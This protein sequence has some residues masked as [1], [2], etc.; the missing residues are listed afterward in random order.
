MRIFELHFNPSPK[1]DLIFDSFCYEPENVYE[2][3]L[4]SLF[5]VGELKNTLPQHLKFFDNLANFLKKQYY[6]A[7]A[8]FS[9]ETALKEGLK[10]TNEFLEKIVKSGD[11]SWLGN[12]NSAVFNLTLCRNKWWEI[13]FTK[14]GDIK[15]LLLRDG[16]I[17]D[18]GKNLEFQDIEPYPLKIFGNIVSGKLVE[19][20]MVLVIT[21]DI[22]SVFNESRSVSVASRQ[23]LKKGKGFNRSPSVIE[24]IALISPFDGTEAK[25]LKDILKLKEQELLKTSG[26]CLLCFLT[27]ETWA[28]DKKPK[29]FTFQ[30]ETEKFSILQVFQPVVKEINL[31]F[32]HRASTHRREGEDEDG[33]LIARRCARVIDAFKGLKL[34]ALKGLE[35]LKQT[36]KKLLK[37]GK[38]RT[39]SRIKKPKIKISLRHLRI[40]LPDNLKKNLVSVFLLVIFLLLGFFIFK[41]EEQAKL[42]EY[43]LILAAVNQDILQADNFLFLKN[44]E[45]AFT[46]LKDSWQ[47]LLPLTEKKSAIQKEAVSLKN[48]LEG[49]LE[50][51]SNLEKIAEPE[52]FFE[53][54]QGDEPKGSSSPFANARVKE[55]I[56]QKMAY[57]E[58]SHYFFSSFSDNVY[59]LTSKAEK[60][61]LPTDQRF[62]EATPLNNY[63]LFL[64]KPNLVFLL[65]NDQFQDTLAL[66]LPYPDFTPKD[67]AAYQ[68]SLYF[69]DGKNGEIIKYPGPIS[70]GKDNPQLWL[71]RDTK[72]ATDAKSVAVNGNVWVLNADNTIFRYFG[73]DFQN[74]I[75][76][77]FFPFPKDLLKISAQLESIYLLEPAQKRLIVLTKTGEVIKQFQS[78][79]FDNLKDFAVSENG[80][81]IWL[82]NGVKVYQIK[83]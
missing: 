22:F 65:S 54:D 62:N 53:F 9:P 74:S 1:E 51:A 67:L 28:A 59:K 66:K 42:K 33:V 29:I 43:K 14:T 46:I 72:K 2:K 45:K 47:K 79:K 56:P 55:F 73:G 26:I 12:L 82:L 44:E 69:L 5:L 68:S 83:F 48:A 11:V 64:Q 31:F 52:L 21:K 34:K 41:R 13:N 76:P 49:K 7:P 60:S 78:E 25:K 16:E 39:K 32:T 80:R 10:R 57:F 36:P 23:K 70:V 77:S 8:R 38:P 15:I 3:R 81:T 50:K 40:E 6:S 58:G 61:V 63:L 17:I 35:R 27:K 71:R 75:V 37:F 24:Q 30:R 18:M 20:D 19:G 4:G